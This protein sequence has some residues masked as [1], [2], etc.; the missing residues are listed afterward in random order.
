MRVIRNVLKTYL[1]Y[2]HKSPKKHTNLLEE[3][4]HVYRVGKIGN[5]GVYD[6][7]IELRK[8]S[9]QRIQ[10]HLS[11]NNSH[12]SIMLINGQIFDNLIFGS[13]ATINEVSFKR[14]A[15]L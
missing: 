6:V 12:K 3:G 4:N 2:S 5:L 9:I 1:V 11:M 7:P 13:F 8:S 10:V 15:L 14:N